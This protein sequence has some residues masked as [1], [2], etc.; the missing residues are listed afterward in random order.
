V[1]H[2]DDWGSVEEVGV[3]RGVVRRCCGGGVVEEVLWRE[4]EAEPPLPRFE[5]D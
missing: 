5:P 1:G 4:A 3:R 2:E